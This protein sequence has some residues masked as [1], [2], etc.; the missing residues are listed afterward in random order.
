VHELGGS[1]QSR[2]EELGAL[3]VMLQG[4]EEDKVADA[5]DDEA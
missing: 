1:K 3:L 2:R 5:L 4:S